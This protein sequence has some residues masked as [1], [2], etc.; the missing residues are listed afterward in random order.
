MQSF[1]K[2]ETLERFRS[3]EGSTV[4]VD[5]LPVAGWGADLATILS[6]VQHYFTEP[7]L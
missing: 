5:Y 3:V 7:S 4:V 1:E 6:C 2:A